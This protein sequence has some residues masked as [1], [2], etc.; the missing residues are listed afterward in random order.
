[1]IG[2]PVAAAIEES[3][4]RG[5]T[6]CSFRITVKAQWYFARR[7]NALDARTGRKD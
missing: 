2:K 5:G 4:L 6:R 3:V 7:E 1:M